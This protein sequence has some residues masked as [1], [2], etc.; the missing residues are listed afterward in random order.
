MKEAIAQDACTNAWRG[1]T[2]TWPER[3]KGDWHCVLTEVAFINAYDVDVN[4]HLCLEP[5]YYRT[6]HPA[7]NFWAVHKN[8]HA[9]ES[10]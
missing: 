4:D 7:G 9:N 8:E 1:Q 10:I 5:K 6:A 3:E 2:L